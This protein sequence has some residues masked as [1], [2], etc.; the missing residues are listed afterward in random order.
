MRYRF[1]LSAILLLGLIPVISL[2][3]CAGKPEP[4]TQWYRIFGSGTD[5]YGR[6]VKQTTDGGYIVCG[7]ITNPLEEG[8]WLIKTDAE[9]NKLWDRIFSSERTAFGESVQQTT[10]GG[11][12]V[13][14]TRQSGARP[15]DIRNDIWLIKT[16]ADGN[17]LWD[18]TFDGGC[19]NFVQKTA[20]GGYIIC[21]SSDDA[22]NMRVRLIKTDAEGNTIWHKIF[23]AQYMDQ[24]NS[25]QQT[26]DG[27][28]I[29]CGWSRPLIEG[30]I[31]GKP[32][33][34]LIKTDAEGNKLWDKM[35]GGVLYAEAA[36]V[37]QTTDGGY[38]I[39]GIGE[40]AKGTG[41][42]GAL[43]DKVTGKTRPLI[44]KTDADGNKL[45]DKTFDRGY[46]YSAQ[47]TTDGG[48]IVC[49]KT[50]LLNG[51]LIKADADG[52]KLWDKTFNEEIEG[53][54]TCNSVQQTADGGYVICGGESSAGANH[55][56]LIKIAP[57]Q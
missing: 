43:M 16:D 27:G 46:G 31:V 15:P 9:G 10:D 3:S 25:V 23:A 6:S 14:G 42:L 1:A 44:I 47:Q 52:N 55:V 39:C 26:T 35:F 41:I 13:C 37:Q 36:S 57:E 49:G 56:L 22:E 38:I 8:V 28:Y 40:S 21:G 34:W 30:W 32:N 5:T 54:T 45:W 4:V 50:L 48:Y 17:K 24:G 11:Y 18:R 12:I 20:D 53:I 19:G 7:K 33:V 51:W 2:F 29:V